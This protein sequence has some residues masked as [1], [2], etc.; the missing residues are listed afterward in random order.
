M[1]E[2]EGYSKLSQTSEAESFAK[3]VNGFK[4]ITIFKRKLHPRDI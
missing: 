3:L 4:K 2:S 1:I